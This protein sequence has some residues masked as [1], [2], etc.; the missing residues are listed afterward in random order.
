MHL[1]LIGISHRT[2]PVDLRER[3]DFQTRG[4]GPRASR[5]GGTSARLAKRSSCPRATAPRSTRRPTISARAQGDLI[6]LRRRASAAWTTPTSHRTCTTL[7]D[8]EAARHLF[9]VAAGLDSLVVGEPQILG[10]VKEAHT[11]AAG[12]QTAGPRAEPAVPFLVRASASACAPRPG[13]DR[14]PSRSATPRSRSRKKIFGDLQGRR[15]L[16]VGA[17][18]MGKLT[19]LHMKSQGVQPRD[20]REPDDGARRADGGSDRRRHG[21][22]VGRARCRARRERHRHHGDRRGL[23]DSDQGARRSGDAAAPQPAALHHR[24][25]AAARRRGRCRRDRAGLPLQ[26]RRSAGDGPRKSRAPIERGRARRSDRHR[27]S[28][29][30]RRLAA[31]ARRHPDGRRA[32]P[33]IRSDSPR[34]A[35]AARVQA[36]GA[37]RR[38]RA[39]ASTRSRAS[40]S[41]SCC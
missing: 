17:G 15:V 13:S 41:K 28:R 38:R 7:A 16:V 10:Q 18:E 33:A 40:S 39:R 22:A 5:R 9:R 35:G 8:L 32:A 26:H 25:R 24:H 19:A 29:E 1:L 36:V 11:I 4:V 3:I 34:R 30:V 27:R 37:R 12:A 31:L 23:A 21:R 6:G 2:A 14:A 20:D